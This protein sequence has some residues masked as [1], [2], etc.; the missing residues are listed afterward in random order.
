M[1]RFWGILT[2]ASLLFTACESSS[3]NEISPSVESVATLPQAVTNNAVAGAYLNDTLF[4]YTFGGID[5][6]LVYTGIHQKS[7]RYNTVTK[8]IDQIPDLPDTL[9]KV[10]AAATTIGDIIYIAGGYHVYEDGHE[11]SSNKLHRFSVAQNR[12]LA[13]GA[14]IP[15]PIDDQVQVSYKDRY[16]YLITGWNDS[17]NVR[18]VQLY[19]TEDNTWK[20]ATPTPDEDIYKSFGASG[21]LT[22]HTIYYLGGASSERQTKFGAQNSLRKGEINP[23]NPTEITW[24]QTPIENTGLLDYEYA[25]RAAAVLVDEAPTW[26]GGSLITYNYDGIAYK[27]KE[28]VT[29]SGLIRTYNPDQGNF[30]VTSLSNKIPMD[31]RGLIQDRQRNIYF[32]GGI[33]DNQ[34]VSNQI[35]KISFK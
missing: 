17:T 18:T 23:T 15:I 27:D 30:S 26:M 35:V 11:K 20:L 33:W 4:L 5:S 9:G 22:D 3:S 13:D 32:I 28:V 7:Y 31:Q 34:E 24:S 8:E 10:A 6:S 1:I 2:A 14:A 29:P 25:Y 21:V 16:L 19:D 12:F